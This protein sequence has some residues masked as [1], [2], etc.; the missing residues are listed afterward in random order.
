MKL[1]N[2]KLQKYLRVK[3]FSLNTFNVAN[4]RL[5]SGPLRKKVEGER[6]FPGSRISFCTGDRS[7]RMLLSVCAVDLCVFRDFATVFCTYQGKVI[8]GTAL[9][10]LNINKGMCYFTCNTIYIFHT[11]NYVRVIFF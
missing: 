7:V 11:N 3:M 6:D 5:I 8:F 4:A 2:Y 10:A 1:Q 9:N